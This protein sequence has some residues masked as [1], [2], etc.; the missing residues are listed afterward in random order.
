MH[1]KYAKKEVAIKESL[2]DLKNKIPEI[3]QNN[4]NKKVILKLIKKVTALN[5]K[6]VI[7]KSIEELQ[8]IEE[9]DF[10]LINLVGIMQ[11]EEKKSIFIK[12]IKH[13]KVK[14]SLFCICDLTYEKVFNDKHNEYENNRK[15]KKISIVEKNE[16]K[17]Y[18]NQVFVKLYENNLT[19]TKGSMEIYFVEM[20]KILGDTRIKLKIGKENIEIKPNDIVV[21]GI[22]QL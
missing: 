18:I 15:L 17:K 7:F 6:D 4:E 12:S 13:G 9:Y 19:R 22:E 1:V 2:Y 8:G 20:S 14:E 16:N 3:L 21:I 5:L 10:Y 11:N